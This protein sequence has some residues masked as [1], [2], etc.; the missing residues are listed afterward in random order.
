MDGI[1]VTD[2]SIWRIPVSE[3]PGYREGNAL[4]WLYSLKQTSKRFLSAHRSAVSG[5]KW[6]AFT[7]CAQRACPRR[8]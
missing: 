6:L 7:L 2:S 4:G 5:K 1:A 8:V 3:L